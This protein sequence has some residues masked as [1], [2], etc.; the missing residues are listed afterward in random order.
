MKAKDI[1]SWLTT[2]EFVF[3]FYLKWIT[4]GV[5]EIFVLC[6]GSLVL[7]VRVSLSPVCQQRG[8]FFISVIVWFSKPLLHWNCFLYFS[9]K[10]II[11][12]SVL[13]FDS[14][15]DQIISLLSLLLCFP[16]L[17][18]SNYSHTRFCFHLQW[19]WTA[20]IF[21]LC[22]SLFLIFICLYFLDEK[23]VNNWITV[24]RIQSKGHAW[25]P[26]SRL[27]K[28]YVWA[29]TTVAFL[30]IWLDCLH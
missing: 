12:I 24:A 14:V 10:K 26:F 8:F 23:H 16:G 29:A 19:G 20:W 18:R 2:H 6:Y 22:V 27:N 4:F 25:P 13:L 28:L 15:A 30:Y 9:I 7:V 5:D 21:F 17:V 11:S 3:L 1:F